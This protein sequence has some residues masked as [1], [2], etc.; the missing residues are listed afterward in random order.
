MRKQW[1][2]GHFSLLPRGLGTRLKNGWTYSSCRRLWFTCKAPANSRT[3]SALIS[4]LLRLQ[5]VRTTEK[6]GGSYTSMNAPK[7][8]ITPP[9]KKT[10]P[11]FW[12]KLLQRVF[13]CPKYTHWFALQY[14]QTLK[15]WTAAWAIVVLCVYMLRRKWYRTFSNGCHP[16]IVTAL[17]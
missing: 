16:Q 3:P 8:I 1:I 9:S 14:M 12:M 13:L 2:P 4:F 17:K 10:K 7:I 5:N 6:K 15:T 11:P